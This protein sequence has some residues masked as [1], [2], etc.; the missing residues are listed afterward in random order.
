MAEDTLPAESMDVGRPA[1]GDML[2]GFY[3]LNIIRQLGLMVG[4]ATSVAIGFAIV[5]W[6]KGEDYRP[7]YGNTANIDVSKVVQVLDSNNIRYKM[8]HN[9]GALLI[10]ADRIHDA[11]L[12]LADAGFPGQKSAGF[13]LL[14]QEQSLGTSQFMETARY[15]RSL[16]GELARSISSINV[17]NRA[18]VHLAVPKSTVF[19]RAK[20][21]PTASVLVDLFP[22]T[23]L[24]PQ[25]VKAIANL[26]A[27]SVPEMQLKDVAVV[28]QKGN[29]LSDFEE[30]TDLDIADKQMQYVKKLEDNLTDRIQRILKPVVGE[31]RFKAEVSADVDFTEIEQTDE[32]YNPD[33][34]AMR[35]EQ[36]LDEQK[37]GGDFAGGIPGALSNQPPNDGAA[38]EQAKRGGDAEQG[39]GVPNSVRKQAT[40]NYELDRTVSY[41]KHQVGNVR[42]LTVAVVVDD[43]VSKD[44]ADSSKVVRT[45]WTQEDLDRLAILVRNAVGFDAA[46]G[47]SVNVINS[48]FV[49]SKQ[50]SFPEPEIWDHPLAEKLAKWLFAFI[51]FLLVVF[52]IIRPAIKGLTSSGKEIRELEAQRAEEAA[53]LSDLA[54]D[55]SGAE[56]VSLSL[57]SGDSLM[58]PSPG[59]SYE[60]QLNTVKGIIAEDPGRVA[61]VVKQWVGE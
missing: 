6:A 33:L 16:E 48:A 47:D 10:A 39:G 18:R 55:D 61:Q 51:L 44:G 1:G 56:G 26:V 60:Q 50:L 23:S 25:Q 22:G 19:I 21:N 32:V 38:P 36:T 34:P 3:N 54:L 7:L 11:R 30:K 17:I 15:R 28:D 40:R 4:L 45:P 46:R 31:G 41:T 27:S 13:E 57:S 58:L 9:S 20:R 2:E 43:I 52:L 42:R 14:D 53:G 12:K 29:L 35:S 37:V 59:E 5:L 49:E 24:K 8:D